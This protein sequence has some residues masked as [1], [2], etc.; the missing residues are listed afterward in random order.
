LQY[1]VKKIASVKNITAEEVAA[2]TTA[3]AEKIFGK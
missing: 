3:N 2:I 1:I